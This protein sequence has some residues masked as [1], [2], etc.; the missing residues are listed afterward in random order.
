MD[1]PYLSL[2]GLQK[3]YGNTPV[4]NNV[5]LEL[6]GGK[7]IGLCGPNG[8]G[9]T[10]LI[11]MIMGLLRDYHGDIKV[12]G[13]D[14]GPKSKARISYLPDVEYLDP[15]A[16]GLSTAKL[17]QDMYADFDLHTLED[18][19]V[20]MKLD[21]SMPVSKMSKGMRE[22]FQL[23]LCLSRQA[24][25]YIFD[26][27]IAGVDPASRDSIIDTILSNYT[28]DALLIISTHLIADIEP[29]LD[30]VVFLKDGAIYLHENC[31]DLREERGASVNDVFREVFK[32]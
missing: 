29:V 7:I 13:D 24:D 9:K 3:A 28:K 10:T 2:R 23:A 19:F 15:R 11:K 6:T 26:E 8:A 31:D 4:I 14:I 21:S 32:W 18:L 20:K 1:M 5:N 30:E 25:I 17:Y 27:P 22:K 16:T 12:L